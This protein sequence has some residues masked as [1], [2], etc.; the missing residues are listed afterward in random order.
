MITFTVIPLTYFYLIG[1]ISMPFNIYIP[2]ILMHNKSYKL[3]K[4]YKIEEIKII[5]KTSKRKGSQL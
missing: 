4:T 3:S 5:A 2:T 1:I